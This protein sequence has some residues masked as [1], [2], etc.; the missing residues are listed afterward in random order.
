MEISPNLIS[1]TTKD[2]N[3]FLR[4]AGYLCGI[5]KRDVQSVTHLA[6]EKGACFVGMIA[7]GDYVV[8]GL[9]EKLAH[10]FWRVGRKIYSDLAHYL[11]GQWMNALC[12]TGPRGANVQFESNDLRK[13]SA[14]WLRQELPVQ[15]IK[16]I[17]C[18]ICAFQ[19]N[20]SRC[21]GGQGTV[22]YE[23]NTQQSPGRGR[24]IAWHLSHS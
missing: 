19:C 7:D 15:R 9:R 6:G 16:I 22:P 17:I 10:K 23:Q 13:P 4:C 3:H 5:V 14:I 24:R 21:L 2:A 8:K 1:D 11:N 20:C 18:T 12:R